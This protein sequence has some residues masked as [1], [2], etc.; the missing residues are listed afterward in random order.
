[1]LRDGCEDMHCEPIRLGE[2]DG[3][4]VDLRF[5]ESRD[6]VNVPSEPVQLGDD[7]ECMPFAICIPQVPWRVPAR[8]FASLQIRAP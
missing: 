5:H 3:N 6:E 1:M 7:Q 8:R 4:E 2:I